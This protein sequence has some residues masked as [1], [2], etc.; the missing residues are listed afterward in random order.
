MVP[1][2]QTLKIKQKRPISYLQVSSPLHLENIPVAD[3][4]PDVE[5]L[6]TI[7]ITNK[8]TGHDEWHPHFLKE[9]ANFINT[10]LSIL[11]GKS[12]KEGAQKSWLKAIITA[13]HKKGPKSDPENYR[14]ISLTSVMSKI[15]ESIVRDAILAHMVKN[16]LLA[17]DQHGFVPARN[18][19]T[20]LLLCLEDW[21]NM[22]ED[23]SM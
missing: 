14:P 3:S 19:I 13:I 18:C 4:I 1:K 9:L 12:L 8:S 2:Q 6:S 23:R 7:D 5:V 17:G 16:N 15:M 10:P 22:I 21:T 20:Q 11:F